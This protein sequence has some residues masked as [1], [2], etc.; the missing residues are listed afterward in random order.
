MF[1]VRELAADPLLQEELIVTVT[2]YPRVILVKPQFK[3]ATF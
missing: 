3:G 2:R 1:R